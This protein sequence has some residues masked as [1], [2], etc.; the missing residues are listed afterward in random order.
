[1][2]P[3]PHYIFSFLK[4]PSITCLVFLISVDYYTN[5][6]K[7]IPSVPVRVNFIL[8]QAVDWV[9]VIVGILLVLEETIL[10]NISLGSILMTYSW[11]S[12]SFSERTLK[13]ALYSLI[14]KIDSR[15]PHMYP[16]LCMLKSLI[17][18][19]LVKW[20]QLALCIQGFSMHRFN[21]PWV[22]ILTTDVKPINMEGWLYIYWEKSI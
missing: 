11:K 5:S 4:I 6:D 18:N 15:K 16:N 8:F 17:L 21:Q 14:K 2:L 13:Y 9:K 20:K 22:K 7:D 3:L 19:G 12:M 10:N 1:M